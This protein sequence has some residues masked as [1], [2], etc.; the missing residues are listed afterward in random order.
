ML[1]NRELTF[2]QILEVLSIDSGHLS[3]HLENL[4]DLVT[5]SSDGKYKLSSFGVA[6]VR[7]MSGVEESNPPAV[8]TRRTRLDTFVRVFSVVLAG[9]LLLVS[10]CAISLT[11]PPEIQD[12]VTVPSLP[13]VTA[14][15]QKFVY[16]VTLAYEGQST[17]SEPNGIRIGIS[18]PGDSVI[19]WKQYHFQLD[20]E[21]NSSMNIV[22][23]VFDTSGNALSNA[24]L[25]GSPNDQGIGIPA[26][27]TQAG[28]YSIE[29]QNEKPQWFYANM[30]LQLQ[31]YLFQRP[32]FYYGLVGTMSTSLY[33]ITVFAVWALTRK[34]KQASMLPK[35]THD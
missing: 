21:Y 16:N 19:E 35:H 13:V 11:T 27:V 34:E 5:R 28:T 15:N 6:A 30:T 3:Y 24:T 23:T 9:T 12:L 25:R 1:Q 29:I 22:L 33:L 2:S 20:F 32:L 4:G 31:Q 17:I 8:S 18:P 10:V 7:L 26:F 14:P